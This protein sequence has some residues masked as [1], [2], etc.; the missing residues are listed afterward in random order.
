MSTYFTKPSQPGVF[1]E[2]ESG[3]R[4]HAICTYTFF[5]A[6]NGKIS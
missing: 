2:R 3:G 5:K 6:K 1:F 4:A